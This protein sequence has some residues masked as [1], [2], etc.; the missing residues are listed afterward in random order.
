[1]TY[2]SL[3][4]VLFVLCTGLLLVLSGCSDNTFSSTTTQ[5]SE[6]APA[7]AYIPLEQ[8][9]R[10]SYVQ[11]E[12]E[13]ANYTVEITDP[14]TISSK[15][16]FTVR[17]TNSTTGEISYQYRYAA[18]NA[19]F[20]TSSLSNPGVRILEGPFVVGHAWDRYNTTISSGDTDV[21]TDTTDTGGDPPDIQNT[22]VPGDEYQTMRIVAKESIVA[23]DGYTY[24]NCLKVS[25]RVG[26]YAY[27]YYWYAA[28][29]GLVKFESVSN[30]LAAGDSDILSVMSDYTH[31]EY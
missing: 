31:I 16:G 30:S 5:I 26:E 4:G 15:A 25:W 9:Q 13:A 11:M 14:V 18:D 27:H 7:S 21:D 20:E 2:R 10:I 22:S 24:A 23:L 12:P 1:M 28:G 17:K 3:T 29:I 6:D 19:I 8:G